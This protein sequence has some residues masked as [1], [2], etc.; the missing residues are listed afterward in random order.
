L[1][2]SPATAIHQE[3]MTMPVTMPPTHALLTNAVDGVGE[4][5]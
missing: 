3:A 4:P 1:S 5:E 2:S